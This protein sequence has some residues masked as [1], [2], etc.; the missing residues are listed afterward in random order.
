MSLTSLFL[1]ILLLPWISGILLLLLLN[2]KNN[3]GAWFS[4]ILST[5]LLVLL[6]Q[7]SW[8][9]E[10][11]LSLSFPWF[12]IGK[13]LFDL[14]F[15]INSTSRAMLLLVGLVNFCVQVFSIKYMEK[16]SNKTRY[17]I[18]VNLFVG[19]MIGLLVAD[20]IW[21]FYGFWELVG[22]SSY[23]IISFW[24][25]KKSAIKAAKK[26][27]LLNRIGDLALLIGLFLLSKHFGVN[28]FSQM[29]VST[30][31]LLGGISG[32]L[33]VLG[34]TGKSAQF[35][36][37]SWLPDA[38]EGPTPASALIHAATMVTAGVFLAIKVFPLTSELTH[39]TYGIFGGI[40]FLSASIFAL[41]QS[42]IK[43]TL[44]YSTI[45]QIGLMWMGLGSDASL[46]HLL[47]HGFF[48]A[49]LF[50]SAGAIIFYV[51]E[52]DKK[53]EIDAQDIKNLGGLLRK[54]P[55]ISISYIIF[56]LGLIGLP[57]S[58]GFYSKE[59]LA[60]YLIEQ[61]QNSSYANL[62]YLLVI[63]LGIGVILSTIYTSRQVLLIFLGQQRSN[64][65]FTK[66]NSPIY[67]QIPLILLAIL[68]CG[69]LF[70]FNPIHLSTSKLIQFSGIELVESP[71]YW[72][73][74]SVFAWAIGLLL[75]FKFRAK[76]PAKNYQFIELFW[77]KLFKTGVRFA[78]FLQSNFER[79]LDY[80]FDNLAKL[81]VIFAHLISWLDRWVVDG[82]L[83][84]GSSKIS[85]IWGSVLSKW[86]SGKV[87][88]YWA[89][90]SITFGL[91]LLYFL[92]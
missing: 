5:V 27:F 3:V 92:L 86:Q 90:L 16:E 66:S 79:T 1:G 26:A 87:Q 38:M 14:N 34:A 9:Q 88:S 53:H 43:K 72:L 18:W 51:H 23:F 22:A 78:S 13:Q 4:T 33:L 62:Y 73:V 31:G 35:P 17:F 44:A 67:F 83:V 54:I 41:F 12:S 55:V 42:D 60:G 76:I 11:D 21:I 40:S 20:Q 68:S 63:S 74:F 7:F 75:A 2:K 84:K 48:K 65:E 46:F 49:G 77:P 70:S 24:H 50:L 25:H 61:S 85:Y 81:Q 10:K 69:F 89:W 37:M 80:F 59:N 91:F 30:F 36:L 28:Q 56:S 15:Y 32:F 82:I 71:T 64:L 6:A 19:S 52:Q 45:S 8:L 39:L 57:L 47:T 58:S 29:Q